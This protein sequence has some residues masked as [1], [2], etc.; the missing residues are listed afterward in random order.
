MNELT[1][2]EELKSFAR[3]AVSAVEGALIIARIIRADTDVDWCRGELRRLAG[4]AGAGVTPA[5]LV[6]YLR[7]QGFAGAGSYYEV[8]NS[9]LEC[10]LRTRRGIPIT[11]AMVVIGTGESIGMTATGIN[12]PSHFM[13]SLDGRLFDPFIMQPIDGAERRAWLAE[14]GA[15]EEDAFKSATPVDVVQRM[16]NNLLALAQSRGD[17]E[18]AL[19]LTDYQLIVAPESLS[20]HVDRAKLWAALGAT[21]MARREIETAIALAPEAAVR[22]RFEKLLRGLDASG[23]TLH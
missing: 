13:V 6:D 7:A 18:A 23:P 12:F 3:S 16:L 8:D 2:A 10:V 22:A 17:H 9:S 14:T 5:E 1:L 19:E 4:E 11:L 15:A 21:E 20:I